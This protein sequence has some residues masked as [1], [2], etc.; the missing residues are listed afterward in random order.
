MHARRLREGHNL[1]FTAQAKSVWLQRR[2]F[3]DTLG[4]VTRDAKLR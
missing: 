3:R 2:L 1:G 4:H